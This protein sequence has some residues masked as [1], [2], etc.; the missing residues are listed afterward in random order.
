[1]TWLM[2]VL[3]ICLEEQVQIKYSVKKH[4]I[5]PKILKYDG[6]KSG[7]ASAVCKFLDKKSSTTHRGTVID[8]KCSF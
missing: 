4:L 3:K 2:E 1:M 5:L 8:S 7:L 6:C